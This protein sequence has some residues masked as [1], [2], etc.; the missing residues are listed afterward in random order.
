MIH[1]GLIGTNQATDDFV[2]AANVTN[3]WELGALYASDVDQADQYAK[4]YGTNQTFLILLIFL[5]TA[6]LIRFSL[7]LPMAI[8]LAIL[9]R[10]F[11]LI[12]MSLRSRQL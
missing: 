5:R 2:Q 1:Y 9:S 8:T 6:I 3:K 12:S 4:K 7:P 10:Q 11:R